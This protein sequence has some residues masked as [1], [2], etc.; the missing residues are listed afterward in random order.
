[1]PI[2]VNHFIESFNEKFNKKI[3]HL[4]SSAFDILTDYNFPGNIR[5]LE[6]VIEHCFILCDSDIIQVEHLPKRLREEDF[7]LNPRHIIHDF[8][9]IRSAEREIIINTLKKHNGN[10]NKTAEELKI[11]PTTLWRKMKKFEII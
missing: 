9:Q 6:N 5:E 3:K 7:Q 4:A 10:R 8:N 1:L 11:H 2:L